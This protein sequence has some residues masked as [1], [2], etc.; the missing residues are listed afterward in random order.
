MEHLRSTCDLHH[1]TCTYV[2]FVQEFGG[3]GTN[4][5]KMAQALR[6]DLITDSIPFQDGAFAYSLYDP[7]TK[8][9]NRHNEVWVAAAESCGPSASQGPKQSMGA[10]QTA[11]AAAK[12]ATRI[13]A[14]AFQH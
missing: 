8:L 4:A 13:V 3:F 5:M 9:W 7:P 1:L 2:V 6:Q 12:T 11:L 14:Q 10:I